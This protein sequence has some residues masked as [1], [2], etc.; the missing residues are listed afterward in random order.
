MGA[1]KKPLKKVE[2]A[3]KKQVKKV[4]YAV[5]GGKEKARGTP[6]P[7]AAQTAAPSTA[8]GRGTEE[9]MEAVVETEGVQRR[10][11]KKGKKQLVTPA[12]SIAVGGEGSSGLNIPKG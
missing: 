8:A 6:P 11:R 9:E 10:R 12:A 3:F 2:R 7:P 5:Q 4:G 1:V